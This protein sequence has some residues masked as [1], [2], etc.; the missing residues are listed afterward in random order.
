M[1]DLPSRDLEIQ[2]K[3]PQLNYFETTNQKSEIYKMFIEGITG[4][5]WDLKLLVRN[6]NKLSNS[7]DK[8]FFK[9]F[10]KVFETMKREIEV[11]KSGMIAMEY[12][13]R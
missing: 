13:L 12:F 3:P 2:N 5:S 10:I 7:D 1:I 9:H 11:S 6:I 8:E 4:F